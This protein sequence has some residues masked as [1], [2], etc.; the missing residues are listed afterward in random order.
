MN[1]LRLKCECG[2]S[3]DPEK[4]VLPA[5]LFCRSQDGAARGFALAFGWWDYH[6]TLLVRWVKTEAGR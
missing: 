1:R 3:S 4:A 6:L 2:K 5:V